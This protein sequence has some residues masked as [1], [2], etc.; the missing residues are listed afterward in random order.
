MS[1]ETD[2]E[3]ILWGNHN[4]LVQFYS[5]QKWQVKFA[6]TS[7]YLIALIFNLYPLDEINV[8]NSLPMGFLPCFS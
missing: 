5:T 6:C 8:T 3:S 7:L 4:S 1:N 2:N